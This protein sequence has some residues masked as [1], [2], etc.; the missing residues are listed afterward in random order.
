MDSKASWK[1]QRNTLNRSRI[2]KWKW[3]FEAKARTI[4]DFCW[5]RF[6]TN[7]SVIAFLAEANHRIVC[8]RTHWVCCTR[9]SLKTQWIKYRK[10]INHVFAR[11]LTARRQHSSM[12]SHAMRSVCAS[13]DEVQHARRPS[14]EWYIDILPIDAVCTLHTP[15]LTAKTINESI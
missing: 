13:T 1:W 2:R 7:N 6:D 14:E 10:T 15:R 9:I 4:F 12:I 3:E 5:C 11:T 8:S